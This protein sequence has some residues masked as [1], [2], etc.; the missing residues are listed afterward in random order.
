MLSKLFDSVPAYSEIPDDLPFAHRE[1]RKRPRAAVHWPLQ[2]LQPGSPEVL[3]TV[4]ENLSSEGLYCCVA[5]RFARGETRECTVAVPVH[6]PRNS[7]RILTLHC[8]VR[9]VRVESIDGNGTVGIG[10]RIEDYH[11]TPKSEL[12]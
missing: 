9:I 6:R 7:C 12:P 1:R 3:N 11:L 10:C 8:K 2:F 4:T 5:G